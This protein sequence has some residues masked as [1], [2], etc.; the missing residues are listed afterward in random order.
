LADH[1]DPTPEITM[2]CT[3]PT[4][5]GAFASTVHVAEPQRSAATATRVSSSVYGVSAQAVQRWLVAGGIERRSPGAP[6]A[7]GGED[8]VA[9]YVAGWSAPAMAERLGCSPS[10]IYRRLDAAGVARRTVELSI[11][12]RELIDALETGMAAPAIAAQAGVSVS[13][14]S[15]ALD[16]EQLVT[17]TQATRQARRR[18]HPELYADDNV[19]VSGNAQH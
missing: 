14:V 1:Q 11:S 6:R 5:T 10:M 2:C 15:R 7:R 3:T 13:C 8:P 19:S 18:R 12:R 4:A 17:R 9:L 16:R